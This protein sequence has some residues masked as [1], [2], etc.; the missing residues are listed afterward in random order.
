MKIKKGGFVT[1]DDY[2]LPDHWW[3]DGVDKAVD[4]VVDKKLVKS[5]Q[6]I[7]HQFI[8]TKY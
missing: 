8:L 4:E 6:I 3:K 7:G 1:G 5:V 2:R